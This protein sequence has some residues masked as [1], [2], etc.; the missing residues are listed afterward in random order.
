MFRSLSSD[1]GQFDR[2]GLAN[3]MADDPEAVLDLLPHLAKASDGNL[4]RIARQVAGRLVVRFAEEAVGGSAGEGRWRPA[5][6]TPGAEL[7]LESALEAVLVGRAL[8]RPLDVHDLQARSWQRRPVGICLVVDTSGSMGADRL[9]A[10]AVTTA[11]LALRAPA[12]FSVIAVSDRALVLK[13]QGS[14]RPADAVIDDLFGLR[15]YGW[16]DLALGLRAARAQLALSPANRK[17]VL[18]LTDG[19]ANRGA[20]PAVEAARLECVHVI[21]PGEVNEACAA[22]ARAGHGRAV[23]FSGLRNAPAAVTALLRG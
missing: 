11:A 10:A 18:L 13:A 16:T 15:S 7:D 8:G 19:Q 4:R 20:D 3:A 6:Y 1:P 9:S 22:I 2:A 12:D 23:G 17:L 14:T 21:V 5:R